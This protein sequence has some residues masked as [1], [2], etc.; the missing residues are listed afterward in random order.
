MYQIGILSKP[1]RSLAL[2]RGQISKNPELNGRT[3][4]STLNFIRSF[5]KH[6]FDALVIVC[7]VFKLE[8]M[9]VINQIKSQ[10]PD[11]PIAVVADRCSYETKT[12]FVYVDKATLLDRRDDLPDIGGILLKMIQDQ[13]VR[14]RRLTRHPVDQKAVLRWIGKD[15]KLSAQTVNMTEKGACFSITDPTFKKGEKISIEI[16]LPQLNKSH[17]LNGEI[18]WENIEKGKGRF[19]SDLQKIGVK[20]LESA[21]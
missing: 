19:G 9:Q 2:V 1:G 16:C 14:P 5:K 20:F 10:F 3:Y 21:S 8:N 18:V 7:E 6:N 17:L 12:Q 13:A 4:T 11:V 15:R